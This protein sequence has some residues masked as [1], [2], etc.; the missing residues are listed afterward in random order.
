LRDAN[1]VGMGGSIV[2]VGHVLCCVLLR[3]GFHY[4]SLVG[5]PP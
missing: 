5:I 3:I 2:T 4:V 1:V